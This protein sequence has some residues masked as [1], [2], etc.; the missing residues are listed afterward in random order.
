VLATLHHHRRFHSAMQSVFHL[1]DG[2]FCYRQHN[3]ANND[4]SWF[5]LWDMNGNNYYRGSGFLSDRLPS[6]TAWVS[7]GKDSIAKV[8]GKPNPQEEEEIDQEASGRASGE[9]Q[10]Q[11]MEDASDEPA[12]IDEGGNGAAADDAGG[13][14]GGGN[15]SGGGGDEG[16]G[17]GGG[18][19]D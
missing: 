17:G 7:S 10:E 11:V 16:G 14:S 6:N 18:G 19:D 1:K 3:T 2:R 5:W 15:E 8:E 4:D 12:G 13:G 9:Q